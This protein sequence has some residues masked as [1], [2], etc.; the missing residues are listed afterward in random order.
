[1]S[2]VEQIIALDYTI[3][4]LTFWRAKGAMKLEGP[5]QVTEE[6]AVLDWQFEQFDEKR[7]TLLWTLSDDEL[8]EYE[9]A[10]KSSGASDDA[11]E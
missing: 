6:T 7:Q 4:L 10:A 5:D 8:Q 3:K 11:A 1:M 9:A 2:S